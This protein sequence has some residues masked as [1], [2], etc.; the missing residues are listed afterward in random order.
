[1]LIFS[2]LQENVQVDN[3]TRTYFEA[4]KLRLNEKTT[5]RCGSSACAVWNEER[6][7]VIVDKFILHENTDAKLH[8]WLICRKWQNTEKKLPGTDLQMYT[9]LDDSRTVLPIT[10]IKTPAHMVHACSFSRNSPIH[11]ARCKVMSKGYDSRIKHNKENPLYVL[12]TYV[13]CGQ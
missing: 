4:E 10:A 2:I 13:S 7:L 8:S 5:L 1:M 9:V 6:W 11:N 3:L 12:N